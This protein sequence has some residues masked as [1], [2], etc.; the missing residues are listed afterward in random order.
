[1]TFGSSYQEAFKRRG[2]LIEMDVFIKFE[3][4]E[5]DLFEGTLKE[6]VFIERRGTSIEMEAITKLELPEGDLFEGA[7]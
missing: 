1:M 4:P 7:L 5:G 6:G 2:A 3:L